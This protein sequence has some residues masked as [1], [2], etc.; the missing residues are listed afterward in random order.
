T[1]TVIPA[2]LIRTGIAPV[3]LAHGARPGVD[4][5]AICANA[6]TVTGPSRAK[7]DRSR[8]DEY[9]DNSL[10]TILPDGTGDLSLSAGPDGAEG[11]HPSGRA[12]R[13]RDE[14][15]VDAGRLSPLA[16]HR[17]PASLREL[18]RLRL[19][20]DHRRRIPAGALDAAHP[21]G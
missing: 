14:R 4:L 21:G 11:L 6:M 12:A 1:D 16:E 8:R 10:T 13:R 20:A 17:L 9:A 7:Q 2:S 18:S 5:L 3:L 15:P 19:R